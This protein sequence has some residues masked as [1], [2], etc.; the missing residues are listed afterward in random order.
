MEREKIYSIS[1]AA[2]ICGVTVKQIRNWEENH[3]IP[4]LER[5]LC[6]E[7][8]YRQFTQEDL[9]VIAKI[10]KYL[11]E[12]YELRTAAGKAAEKI[13]QSEGENKNG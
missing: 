12:G 9:K 11:D 2:R 8:N 3:Y 4:K 13:S 6:G 1:E 7:R 5:V 10:K